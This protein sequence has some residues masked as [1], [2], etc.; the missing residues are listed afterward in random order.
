MSN[1]TPPTEPTPAPAPAPS[2]APATD[3]TTETPK[4]DKFVK[5]QLFEMV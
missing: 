1:E 2:P 4:E 5:D 3:T